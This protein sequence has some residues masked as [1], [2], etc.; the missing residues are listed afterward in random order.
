[1]KVIF[2]VDNI[3]AIEM[4]VPIIKALPSNWEVLV[5]NYD[6]WTRQKRIEIESFLQKLALRY[7]TIGNRSQRGV[8]EILQE[9][10][11]SVLVL[12]RDEATRLEQ[13][14]IEL[15]NSRHVPTLL[16]PHGI[17]APGERKTWGIRG[18]FSWV[19]HLYH[20]GFQG[21]RVIREGNFSWVRLIQTVLFRIKH[22]LRRRPLLP[23]HGGCSRIAAFGD[24]MKELLVSEGVSPE[25]ITVTG[26][27][28]FDL[29]YNTKKSD[30]ESEIRKSLGI[31]NDENIVLLLTDYLVEFGIWTV[32]QRK[33]RLSCRVWNLDGS[34]KEKIHHGDLRNSSTATGV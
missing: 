14:F 25:H 18:I 33:R 24:A 26:N 22:D 28:K 10:Q 5:I 34:T 3:P 8:E 29:L 23:G 32:A 17:W 15:A 20:L 13:L 1:M 12:A 27:P 4:F 21:Y 2:L 31:T 19:R 16:V 11:P 6:G 7:R 9:E 30:R